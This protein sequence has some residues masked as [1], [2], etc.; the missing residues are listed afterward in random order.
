MSLCL[1]L[2]FVAMVASIG[3]SA[4]QDS[5]SRQ[6]AQAAHPA[7]DQDS[8]SLPG[9]EDFHDALGAD[10]NEQGRDAPTQLA[11]QADEY[12]G[13]G[14]RRVSAFPW[15]DAAYHEP[16]SLYTVST[17]VAI[18]VSLTVRNKYTNRYLTVMAPL[19]SPLRLR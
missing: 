8:Y 19:P 6:A 11:S 7:Q 13:F 4:A 3:A 10:A 16:N 5:A 1:K 15:V 12:A 18:T 17:T 2:L 9:H 14:A